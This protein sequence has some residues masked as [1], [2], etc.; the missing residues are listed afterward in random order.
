M[1]QELISVQP[2]SGRLS[3]YLRDILNLA[4]K[5]NVEDIVRLHFLDGLPISIHPI[6]AI[7]TYLTLE[8]FDTLTDDLFPFPAPSQIDASCAPV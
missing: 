4:S 7:Q 2:F 6:A 5:L 3:S 8:Q 1:F